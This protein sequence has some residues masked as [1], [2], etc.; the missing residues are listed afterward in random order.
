VE[1]A[2]FGRRTL[3]TITVRTDFFA[4][5]EYPIDVRVE[6]DPPD[7][8]PD[9]DTGYLYFDGD[10]LEFDWPRDFFFRGDPVAGSYSVTV[11]AQNS[12]TIGYVTVAAGRFT[13]E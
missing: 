6:V 11:E 13:I 8:L 12:S 3:F 10:S 7:G 4:D 2:R 5:F 1:C 9:R